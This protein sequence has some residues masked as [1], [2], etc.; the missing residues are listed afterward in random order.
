M[1]NGIKPLSV[2]VGVAF[3]DSGYNEELF[4]Q[5][6]TALYT[7]KENGKRGCEIFGERESS[8]KD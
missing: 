5:A 7:V 2:S 3:S 8:A 4:K 6:D 1:E